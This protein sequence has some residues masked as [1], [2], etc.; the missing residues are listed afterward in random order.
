[1]GKNIVEYKV[2]VNFKSRNENERRGILNKK[3]AGI[4]NLEVN[5]GNS[6]F[7]NGMIRKG[8]DVP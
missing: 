2:Y 8:N 3:L 1:M 6:E 5:S 4:I 7:L